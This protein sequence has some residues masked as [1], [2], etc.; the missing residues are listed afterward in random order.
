MFRT[1]FF[2]AAVICA[3]GAIDLSPENFDTL[4]GADKPAF[5][6]FFAPWCGHCKRMAPAWKEIEDAQ[7]KVV[8]GDVDCTI[9]RE[10]CSKFDVKGFPTLKTFAAGSQEAADYSGGRNMADLKAQVDTM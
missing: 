7:D 4:V 5:V 9:H 3:V 8:I 6:K 2:L 1:L 10:L